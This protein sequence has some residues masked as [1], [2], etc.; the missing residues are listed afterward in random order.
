MKSGDR[1]WGCG[2]MDKKHEKQVSTI[3]IKIDYVLVVHI[4]F[5]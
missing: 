5:L 3:L 2:A 1:L 4:L